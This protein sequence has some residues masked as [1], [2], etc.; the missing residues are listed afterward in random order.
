MSTN[1]RGNPKTG[2][3]DPP[4]NSSENID[5]LHTSE[6]IRLIMTYI[7]T[8]LICLSLAIFSYDSSVKDSLFRVI[9]ITIIFFVVCG[10]FDYLWLRYYLIENRISDSTNNR[11]IFHNILHMLLPGIVLVFAYTFL[12]SGFKTSLSIVNTKFLSLFIIKFISIIVIIT[13]YLY[14]TIRLMNILKEKN[15]S[16]NTNTQVDIL[17]SVLHPVAILLISGLFY[18]IILIFINKKP[19]QVNP[20]QQIQNPNPIK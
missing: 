2:R 15:N 7:I 1:R 3:R 11:D 6:V 4:D 18:S 19:V 9:L 14:Y 13:A 16:E 10:L 5:S 8:F 20:V 17:Y 12:I